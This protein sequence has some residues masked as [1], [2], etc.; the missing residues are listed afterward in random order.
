M[1][2]LFARGPGQTNI[3]FF[4]A[5]GQEILHLDLEVTLDS[6]GLKQLLDRS[7]PGNDIQVD[8]TGSNIVLKGTAANAQ[9][10][11]DG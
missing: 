3:F 10:S 6:K 11:Q 4:D 9:R 2:Y 5:N 1:A 8:S 7:I